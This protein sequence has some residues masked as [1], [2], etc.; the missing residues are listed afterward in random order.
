MHGGNRMALWVLHDILLDLS[1][2]RHLKLGQPSSWSEV[3]RKHAHCCV[4][5]VDCGQEYLEW[6]V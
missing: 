3:A 5:G 6:D 2:P 1:P 4:F